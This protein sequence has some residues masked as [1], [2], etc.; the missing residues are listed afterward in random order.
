[1]SYALRAGNPLKQ[2]LEEYK[3]ASSASSAPSGRDSTGVMD[4]SPSRPSSPVRRRGKRRHSPTHSP[5]PE[6]KRATTND[7][8][9]EDST[10]TP[11]PVDEECS[12]SHTATEHPV[13]ASK[14]TVSHS[15]T[16]P[17]PQDS[18]DDDD[19]DNYGTDTDNATNKTTDVDGD[20]E[21]GHGLTEPND[22]DDDDTQASD[23][24][25]MDPAEY[26][27][28]VKDDYPSDDGA[29][30]ATVSEAELPNSPAPYPVRLSF[31]K[32]MQ[33]E[34][35]NESAGAVA[36][37]ADALYK[38]AAVLPTQGGSPS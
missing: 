3:L 38:L 26:L 11:V 27:D 7:V 29:S 20:D 32:D 6:E 8:A 17:L 5:Q 35:R 13:S 37:D 14:D 22:Q 12:W 1:M 30:F 19:E 16:V 2:S 24:D 15:E 31:R 25:P 4:C 33:T 18:D 10:V 36:H 9:T 34:E 28:L 23:E 21:T